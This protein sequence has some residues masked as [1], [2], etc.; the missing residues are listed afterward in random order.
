ML[1]KKITY[2]LILA[3]SMGVLFAGCKTSDNDTREQASINVPIE[4]SYAPSKELNTDDTGRTVES[5]EAQVL[6]SET[7]IPVSGKINHGYSIKVREEPDP[8]EIR[9]TSDVIL[10]EL[11]AYDFVKDN[12]NIREPGLDFILTDTSD[13]DP[14][15]YMWY[16]FTAT[17]NGI[18]VMNATF[19]VVA[20]TDGSILEGRSEF[21]EA[22][23]VDE[24]LIIPK[25]EALQKYRETSGDVR[26]LRYIEMCYLFTGRYIERCQMVYVYRY[27]KGSVLINAM[28][29]E[30]AGA[31]S[32]YID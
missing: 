23:F 14:S 26:E 15:A 21:S 7:T 4:K 9:R 22:A 25:E 32:D 10:T 31:Y 24:D 11:E 19:T 27:N 30:L 3:L 6:S 28:T 12:I 13:D 2:V 8:R 1:R 16:E 18:K 17:F 29:G 20:F 5:S